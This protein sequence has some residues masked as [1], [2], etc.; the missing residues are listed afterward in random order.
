MD[1]ETEKDRSRVRV[2]W[3]GVE[4]VGEEVREGKEFALREPAIH[5]R[6][7]ELVAFYMKWKR[8]E[9]EASETRRP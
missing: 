3:G 9:V 7:G 2:R 6:G 5:K 8:E 4:G 1:E